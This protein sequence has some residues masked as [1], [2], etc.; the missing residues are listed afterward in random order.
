MENNSDNPFDVTTWL[1]T[2]AILKQ[3][4]LTSALTDCWLTYF[5]G[6]LREDLWTFSLKLT[7]PSNSGTPAK[8]SCK[9]FQ[10]NCCIC[11]N[12][13]I[14][15][16]ILTVVK[17]LWEGVRMKAS[18]ES[19]T[20]HHL[21]PPLLWNSVVA[22]FTLIEDTPLFPGRSNYVTESNTRRWDVE[23]PGFS[24]KS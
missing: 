19:V 18:W 2:T 17:F 9:E 4:F 24:V 7:V 8:T 23:I 1:S 10:L 22:A 16:W 20:K 6:D 13:D 5:A 21:H 12:K 11:T 3:V 15:R 14:T